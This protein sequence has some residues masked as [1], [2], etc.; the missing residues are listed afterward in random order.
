MHADP[1]GSA[2]QAMLGDLEPAH[3]TAPGKA[4]LAH[5]ASWRHSI[6]AQPLQRHTPRTLTDRRDLAADLARTRARGHATDHGEHH[7][8]RH[9]I[10][11]PIFDED[12]PVAAL[13]VTTTPSQRG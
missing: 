8:D 2:P 5:R 12:H 9:A 7:Q 3:A 11:A 1:D 10:A 6:L 13:A 4:L